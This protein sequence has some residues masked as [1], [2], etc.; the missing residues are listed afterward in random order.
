L[1][2]ELDLSITWIFAKLL[3][4]VAASSILFL[5]PITAL[6][7]C[8][9]PG[10]ETPGGCMEVAVGKV[11]PMV[12][13]ELESPSNELLCVVLSGGGSE[14]LLSDTPRASCTRL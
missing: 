2:P 7:A 12:D 1:S 14:K 6:T 8:G 3:R 9:G 4:Q 10:D 11:E 13:K 5:R